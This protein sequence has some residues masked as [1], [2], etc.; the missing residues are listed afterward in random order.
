MLGR[1]VCPQLVRYARDFWLSRLGAGLWGWLP[2]PFG[3]PFRIGLDG[4][5]KGDNHDVL[6]RLYRLLRVRNGLSARAGRSSLRMG[7]QLMRTRLALG[8]GLFAIWA[9]QTAII[10]VSAG[11]SAQFTWKFI[12]Y[13]AH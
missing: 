10:V 7:R 1:A 11:A 13:M 8:A 4:E 6:S 5:F 9:L 12:A 2:F 3:A